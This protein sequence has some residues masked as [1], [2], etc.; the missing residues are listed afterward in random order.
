MKE[1]KA[2]L[3]EVILNYVIGYLKIVFFSWAVSLGLLLIFIPIAI[4]LLGFSY[5]F[6]N[7]SFNNVINFLKILAEYQNT[8]VF[9]VLVVLPFIIYITEK[10]FGKDYETIEHKFV[11]RF[12]LFSGLL[13]VLLWF[14]VILIPLKQYDFISITTSFFVSFVIILLMGGFG[15]YFY[16]LSEYFEDKIKKR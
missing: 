4:V 11:L 6:Y 12:F 14:I 9:C 15:Y 1:T 5:F 3:K 16:H 13:N 8:F 10:I 2:T 7:S